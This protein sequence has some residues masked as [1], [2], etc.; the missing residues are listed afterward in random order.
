VKDREAGTA[1]AKQLFRL[2]RSCAVPKGRPGA[3]RKW[4]HSPMGVEKRRAAKRNRAVAFALQSQATGTG[5][6]Q[7]GQV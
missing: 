1:S 4:A 3:K 6:K 2:A 5:K 7:A